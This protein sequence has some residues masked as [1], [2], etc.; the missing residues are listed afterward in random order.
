M[1]YLQNKIVNKMLKHR[2]IEWLKH[3]SNIYI[4]QNKRILSTEIERLYPKMTILEMTKCVDILSNILWQINNH[5][6]AKIN[7][8][9]QTHGILKAD[10][11]NYYDLRSLYMCLRVA[12]KLQREKKNFLEQKRKEMIK[13]YNKSIMV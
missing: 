8:W 4:K 11:S 9:E 13:I 7:W 3:L 10:V 2:C 6:F 12:A 1:S 5:G